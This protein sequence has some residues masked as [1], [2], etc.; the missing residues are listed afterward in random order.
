MKC[1]VKI[2]FFSYTEQNLLSGGENGDFNAAGRTER[3]VHTE[4][5]LWSTTSFRRMAV[6]MKLQGS[7]K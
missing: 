7:G 2:S 1:Y 5:A 3:L 4:N 6:A